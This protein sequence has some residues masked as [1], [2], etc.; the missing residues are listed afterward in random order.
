MD[1][2]GS[3]NN[4]NG[5]G[6]ASK[7]TKLPPSRPREPPRDRKR[8]PSNENDAAAIG[9]TRGTENEGK[10]NSKEGPE[11]NKNNLLVSLELPGTTRVINDPEAVR[12]RHHAAG[13]EAR[14]LPTRATVHAHH[15]SLLRCPLPSRMCRAPQASRGDSAAP[16]LHPRSL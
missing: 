11:T 12:A 14:G 9:A 5:D 13:D 1:Q 10:P 6:G 8:A 2:T 4:Q 16:G 7:W 15:V 3:Q